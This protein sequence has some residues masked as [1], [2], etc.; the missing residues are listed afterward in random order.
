MWIQLEI[1]KATVLIGKGA[2]RISLHTTVPS[3]FPKTISNENLCLEFQTPYNE[4]VEYL[5]KAFGITDLI[6][7][8]SE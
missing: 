2:D 5:Q 7:I 3:P 6:I 4:G 8:R 1:K